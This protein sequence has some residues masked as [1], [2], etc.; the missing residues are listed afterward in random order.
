[1]SYVF[2]IEAALL[3]MLVAGGIADFF[4]KNFM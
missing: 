2:Y 3:F 4:S 1:M